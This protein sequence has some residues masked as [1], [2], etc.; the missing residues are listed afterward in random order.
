MLKT[1]LS[2]HFAQWNS[3]KP[4][5]EL[6]CIENFIVSWLLR[7]FA[8]HLLEKILKRQDSQQSALQ[9]FYIV[10]LFV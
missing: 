6:L 4:A 5:L 9:L 1:Q 2:S 8:L 10:N 3:Q 7:I